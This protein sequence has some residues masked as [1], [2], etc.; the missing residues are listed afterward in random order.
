MCRG[1]ADWAPKAVSRDFFSL[2]AWPPRRFPFDTKFRGDLGEWGKS[3]KRKHRECFYEILPLALTPFG[4]ALS[5]AGYLARL[6]REIHGSL[7]V[8]F[9]ESGGARTD[10]PRGGQTTAW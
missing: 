2:G 1:I 3:G 7:A 5:R 10:R 4:A 8:Y 6:D 9:L